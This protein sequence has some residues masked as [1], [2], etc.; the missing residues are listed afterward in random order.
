[1]YMAIQTFLCLYASGPTTD[2]VTDSDGMS[3]TVFIYVGFALPLAILRFGGRDITEKLVKIL[4][5]RGYTVTA[6]AERE[7][8]PDI[9]EIL[10]YMRLEYH[11]EH[12]LTAPIGKENTY[13]VPEE[14]IITVAELKSTAD[15]DNEKTYE[16][17]DGNISTVGAG[18]FRCVEV[19]FLPSPKI[20]GT[21]SQNIMKCDVDTYKNLNTIVLLSGGT[22]M[23]H[24]KVE[25][26]TNELMARAPS[27]KRS[28]WSLRSCMDWR[29]YL[30]FVLPDGNIIT[31]D[32]KRFLNVEV[33]FQPNFIGERA[34]GI[35]DTSLQSNKKC[36][37]YIR[38]EMYA[39]SCYQRHDH[40]PRDFWEHD[41][42]LTA[43]SPST[44]KFKV[45]AP[46]E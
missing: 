41:K 25:R 4:T 46:P 10:C 43:L 38:N 9:E 2:T 15:S 8:V 21:S 44:M 23:F 11:T 19:L 18:R 24:E 29:I 13:V 39:M 45:F 6:I 32:A 20:H 17:P 28:R 31:V 33:L 36:D 40:V 26:M 16:L 7:I 30:V 42:E 12:K 35:H 5:E 3:H 1:M 22:S 37:V 34:S 14:N 27:T